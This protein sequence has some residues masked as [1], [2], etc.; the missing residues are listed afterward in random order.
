[1]ATGVAALIAAAGAG[2][3]LAAAST[4]ADPKA[5]R[6]LGARSLLEWSLVALAPHVDHVV[7]AVPPT[8]VGSARAALA[9]AVNVTVL[10]GG[11]TRQESVAMALVAVDPAIELVLVHDAARPLVPGEVIARVIEALR[12]GAEAVA[13]VVP[14]IDSLRRVNPD[15]SSA[16]VDR[17]ALRAVQ[18]PQGFRRQVL[19]RAHQEAPHL[20]AADDASLVERSGVPVHLVAGSEL[21]L[22]ITRPHDLLVAEAILARQR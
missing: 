21:A 22:K 9:D 14:V 20:G 8:Y 17:T 4:C 12:D 5:F 11:A 3:R 18:T 6:R 7:V 2:S 16:A 10:A 13:P 19:L 15:G 1:V